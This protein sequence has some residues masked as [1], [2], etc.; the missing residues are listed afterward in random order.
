ML[1]RLRGEKERMD[2]HRGVGAA[3]ASGGGIEEVIPRKGENL[4]S[5][6]LKCAS[7]ERLF[8]R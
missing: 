6:I 3:P 4:S 5:V 7:H 2:F 8:S 1:V